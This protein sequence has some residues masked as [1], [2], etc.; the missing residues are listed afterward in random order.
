MNQSHWKKPKDVEGEMIWKN[1]LSWRDVYFQTSGRSM[2]LY[3]KRRGIKQVLFEI[4]FIKID[5]IIKGTK[6]FSKNTFRIVLISGAIE[7]FKFPANV[8]QTTIHQ[9]IGNLAMLW[10][11]KDKEL[12]ESLNLNA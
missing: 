8:E 1:G 12:L 3:P 10:L 9:W 2:Y 5:E 6:G 4:P 11:L 7:Q